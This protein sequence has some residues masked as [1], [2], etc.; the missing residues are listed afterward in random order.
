MTSLT[1]SPFFFFFS[2]FFSS[3]TQNLHVL[4][5]IIKGFIW[6]IKLNLFIIILNSKCNLKI[7]FIRKKG[8]QVIT[9]S[10]RACQDTQSLF[11][12]KMTSWVGL[13]CGLYMLVP[14]FQ[15][16]N[17]PS[18][19]F[20]L[21]QTDRRYKNTGVLNSHIGQK[22]S[23]ITTSGLSLFLHLHKFVFYCWVNYTNH[24]CG[25]TK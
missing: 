7:F 9:C 15:N 24:P 6:K 25:I 16:K 11:L 13:T 12:A 2:F 14:I 17:P 20:S 19:L 10:L 5:K 23:Q 21:N 4:M 1:C 22:K 3:I 18:I 8:K